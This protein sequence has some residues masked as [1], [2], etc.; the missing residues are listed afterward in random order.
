MPH[1][2]ILSIRH[3]RPQDAER[4][5]RVLPCV[6][7]PSWSILAVVVVLTNKGKARTAKGRPPHARPLRPQLLGILHADGPA[8]GRGGRDL[9]YRR[10]AALGRPLQYRR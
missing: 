3:S 8:A 9:R 1:K 7:R 2:F 6:A 10:Y 4:R 5:G